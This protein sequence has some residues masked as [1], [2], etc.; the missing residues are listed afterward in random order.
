MECVWAGYFVFA[1]PDPPCTFL[2]LALCLN[3]Y[4]LRICKLENT[5]AHITGLPCSLA[6][7]M[8]DLGRVPA[9]GG[10]RGGVGWKVKLRCF[11]P[12][13]PPRGVSGLAVTFKQRT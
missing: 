4:G 8:S 11:F 6:S 7:C 3:L 12:G 2:F 9:G 13:L 5:V 1:P 10:D